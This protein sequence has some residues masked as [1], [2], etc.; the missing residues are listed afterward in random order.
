MQGRNIHRALLYIHSA[1]LW[2]IRLISKHL[3]SSLGEWE[4]TVQIQWF[5]SLCI[6]SLNSYDNYAPRLNRSLGRMRLQVGQLTLKKHAALELCVRSVLSPVGRVRFLP[7]VVSRGQCSCPCR[8][9]QSLGVC[10]LVC[11]W[12]L[13]IKIVWRFVWCW[14]LCGKVVVSGVQCGKCRFGMSLVLFTH[15]TRLRFRC[16]FF[17][18]LVFLGGFQCLL[19]NWRTYF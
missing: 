19:S 5:E 17:L 13:L 9:R 2:C 7:V 18:L 16:A 1:D 11:W 8:T 14:V 10:R 15:E 12:L 3:M 4:V 6:L